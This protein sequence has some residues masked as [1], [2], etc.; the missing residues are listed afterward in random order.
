MSYRTDELTAAVLRWLDRYSPPGRVA[1]SP[2]L[3]EAER[4]ALLRAVLSRAPAQTDE[5]R[6]WVGAL[7]DAA[8]R[9][10]RTRAWPSVGDIHRAADSLPRRGGAA[11]ADRPRTDDE[12]AAARIAAGEPV[13]ETWVFGARAS[14]LVAAGLV[15][16]AQLE[17][18]RDGAWQNWRRLHGHAK[19]SAMRAAAAGET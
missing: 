12:L 4:T 17:P 16:D 15:T 13:G 10:M 7:L 6:E 9:A 8:E 14:N 2:Q 11:L 3:V 18:Y 5:C 19:A 1:A